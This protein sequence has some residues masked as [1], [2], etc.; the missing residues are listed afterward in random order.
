MAN[1]S[2]ELLR[3]FEAQSPGNVQA[4]RSH[5]DYGLYRGAA[6]FCRSLKGKSFAVG[7]KAPEGWDWKDL[8]EKAR[9]AFARKMRRKFKR[10]LRDG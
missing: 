2:L 1:G 7:V 5:Y 10:W 9:L 6:Y 8:E 4:R 3:R